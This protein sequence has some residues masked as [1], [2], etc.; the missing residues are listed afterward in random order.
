MAVDAVKRAAEVELAELLRVW[1]E[2]YVP[3]R[4]E[5]ADPKADSFDTALTAFA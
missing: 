1:R 5:G 4:E 2:S 3:V